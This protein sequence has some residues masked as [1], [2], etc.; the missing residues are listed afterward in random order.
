MSIEY[1]ETLWIITIITVAS[2][3]LLPI[4]SWVIAHRDWRQNNS[5]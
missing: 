1:V 5:L 2:M 3:I 4:F